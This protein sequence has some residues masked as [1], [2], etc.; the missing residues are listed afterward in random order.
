MQPG[1][2][3]EKPEIE[4]GP[5]DEDEVERRAFDHECEAISDRT[6]LGQEEMFAYY[7]LLRW[8]QSQTPEQMLSRAR[9]GVRYGDLLEHP[10]EYRGELLREK[11]HIARVR[12]EDAKPGIP[13]DFQHYYEALGW[14]DSTQTWF[15]FCIFVDLP[16]G[17]PVG[18]RVYEEGTFVGYFLKTF[19]YLDG[20]GKK[21]KAPILIG[22]MIYHPPPI[23]SRNAD[24][25]LWGCA[26]GGVLFVLFLARWGWRLRGKRTGAPEI[27]GL[28][29][30]DGMP[31]TEG[32]V[33]RIE[34]WLEQAESQPA[35]TEIKSAANHDLNGSSDGGGMS[36]HRDHGLDWTEDRER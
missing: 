16:E 23:V 4:P 17:M 18:D 28:L 30:R 27:K 22:R 32:E 33:L 1:T 13:F 25:W 34:D 36:L 35:E 2:E 8:A 29:R 12:R 3:P 5:L 21:T 15:Y 14:N 20:Q 24:E 31:E 7:R 26:V 10:E 6:A 19:V 9:G 11:L